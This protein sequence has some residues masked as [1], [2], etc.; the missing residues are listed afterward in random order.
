MT[1]NFLRRWL[2]TNGYF[3]TTPVKGFSRYVEQDFIC[4]ELRRDPVIMAEIERRMAG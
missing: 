1:N 4:T 2:R 3:E